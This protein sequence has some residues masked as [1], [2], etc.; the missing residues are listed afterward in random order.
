M[1]N[2]CG[3]NC[4]GARFSHEQGETLKEN[5]DHLI[6]LPERAPV[7]PSGASGC[8]YIPGEGLDCHDPSEEMPII[9]GAPPHGGGSATYPPS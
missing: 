9:G 3:L 2:N 8:T 6:I 1:K 7:P 5:E 4:K